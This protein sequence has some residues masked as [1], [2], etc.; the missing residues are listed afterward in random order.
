MLGN[1][2]DHR[3]YPFWLGL[4]F[5]GAIA[6]TTAT[7]DRL[8]V[9][10]S[11]R[12]AGRAFGVYVWTYHPR[13][14][15]APECPFENSTC[16]TVLIRRDSPGATVIV[17]Y[18]EL[19]GFGE[20]GIPFPAAVR[21]QI[22]DEL[23][24][25]TQFELLSVHPPTTG[26]TSTAAQAPTRVDTHQRRRWLWLGEALLGLHASIVRDSPAG[27]GVVRYGSPD[28]DNRY[29]IVT[30]KPVEGICGE[31]GCPPPVPSELLGYGTTLQ[32]WLLAR[33][34][35]SVILAPHPAQVRLPAR[36]GSVTPTTAR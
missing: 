21:Q 29:Y 25:T 19:V 28:A 11:L 17:G 16:K 22:S 26:P 14:V 6:G 10:Y 30:Y 4:R 12:Y 5:R 23:R 15:A 3:Y 36:V 13:L 32:T 1:A 34:W 8:D 27:V 2:Q 18:N 31:L 33:G 35:L 24:Q 9:S 7:S 20:V